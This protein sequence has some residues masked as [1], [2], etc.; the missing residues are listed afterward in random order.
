[1]IRE[2]HRNGILEKRK[3]MRRWKTLYLDAKN[4]FYSIIRAAHQEGATPTELSKL[5]ELSIQ[6]IGQI[7][8]EKA[9][10]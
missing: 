3:I 4:D 10:E 6:R 7:I 9:D 5:L 8:Y 1:M 2:I